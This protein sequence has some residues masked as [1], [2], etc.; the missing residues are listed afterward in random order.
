MPS[1]DCLLAMVDALKEAQIEHVRSEAKLLD[2][3]ES[4]LVRMEESIQGLI[5]YKTR[6]TAFIGGM[7]F[8]GTSLAALIATFI[9]KVMS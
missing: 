8:L 4:K 3:I 6:T 5:I 2:K 7:W 1:P 9:H